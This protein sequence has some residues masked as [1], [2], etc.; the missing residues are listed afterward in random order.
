[1]SDAQ[2]NVLIID[3]EENMLHMLSAMLTGQGY[4]VDTAGD[5]MA[6]LKC[7]ESRKFD[8][9]LCDIKMPNMDGMSFLTAAVSA[10]HSAIIIMMSAFGTVD[11]A[12]EAMK[13][14]AYDYISKP[15]KTD[16]VIL[17]LKKAEERESLRRENI[18]LKKRIAGL[19]DS[20]GL[21]TMIGRS[22]VMQDVFLLADK[23]AR[24]MTTVLITG[25]SGT[26]KELAAQG[27]H[28]KS[29]R[30][31][32]AFV[33]VNC[34]SVPE[35]LLESE[36][37]GHV[38][39]AFTGAD[40]EKT[41]LFEE[42]DGGTLF[43]DEIGELPPNMQVKLLRVLQEREVR[44]VG[45]EKSRQVDV[46]IIAATAR[47][48]ASDV[49]KGQFREDLY[50]RLNVIN[51]YIPPLRDR[52]E[53]IPLLCDYFIEKYALLL[54]RHD[55]QS[56]S[57]AAMKLLMQYHWPG[58]VRELENVIERAVILAEKNIIL[59]E[60]LPDALVGQKHSRRLDDLLGTL[61][62]RKGRKILEARLIT[63]ALAATGG[64]KS[65]AAELLEI[66]YPS[67][68]GKIREYK[69]NLQSK[70]SV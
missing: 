11:T 2:R 4:S 43:L 27:I 57:P 1:M 31:N 60:N 28:R 36:F 42:A 70:R 29:P 14:G 10:G 7:L 8:F 17:V 15:F 18:L 52:M 23:V 12:I 21:G 25:E 59:P 6:G 68:L 26:G 9:V 63:R 61:S 69:I 44:K 39:G 58:N 41:G 40:R 16:E 13:H 37:F 47:D 46:R 33:A 53:D 19:E 64:N 32:R 50:Y 66:S 56:V 30:A 49:E 67:L 20:L 55:V 22:K 54:D 51:L 24:H 34:G 3:D 62:I 5:G 65:R 35:N 45:A 48:L 38:R